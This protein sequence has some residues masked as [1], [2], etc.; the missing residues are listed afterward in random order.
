VGFHGELRS[1]ITNFQHHEGFL[2][3]YAEET[4]EKLL[5]KVCIKRGLLVWKFLQ[6]VLI[7]RNRGA[8]FQVAEQLFYH[9]V[10]FAF[11]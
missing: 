8:L 3:L 4:S 7:V 1:G 2:F 5:P 11:E 6:R 10:L 9:R